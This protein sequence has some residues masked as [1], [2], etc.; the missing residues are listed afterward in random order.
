[1]SIEKKK[2]NTFFSKVEYGTQIH[3]EINQEVLS[4]IITHLL[5]LITGCLLNSSCK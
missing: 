2:D 4:S 5:L 1:M 3:L